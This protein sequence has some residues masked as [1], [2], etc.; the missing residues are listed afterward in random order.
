MADPKSLIKD[1]A[2]PVSGGAQ[3]ERDPGLGAPL[4]PDAA[5]LPIG[6]APNGVP[7]QGLDDAPADEAATRPPRLG[8]APEPAASEPDLKNRLGQGERT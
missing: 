4:D 6:D 5:Q 1:A 7:P 2:T 8:P 3:T